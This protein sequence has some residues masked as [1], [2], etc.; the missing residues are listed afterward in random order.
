M[1]LRILNLEILLHPVSL[2]KWSMSIEIE[3][4]PLL[5]EGNAKTSPS[6]NTMGSPQDLA[7]VTFWPPDPCQKCAG[8]TR[9]GKRLHLKG[10]VGHSQC[11]LEEAPGACAGLTPG[12]L[13]QGD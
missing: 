1:S 2:Q 12:A 3:N 8:P 6:R 9:A 4:I 7:R 11:A 13:D 10:A 5:L